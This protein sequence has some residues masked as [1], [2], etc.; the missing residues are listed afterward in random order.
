MKIL[1]I[2]IKIDQDDNTIGDFTDARDTYTQ[3]IQMVDYLDM[4]HNMIMK[5]IFM[6]RKSG[7]NITKTILKILK[8]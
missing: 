8:P 6:H 2:I 5:I 3:S 1:Y 7:V 4:T